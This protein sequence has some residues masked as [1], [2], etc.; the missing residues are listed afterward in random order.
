MLYGKL[1]L[2]ECF[3]CY[4]KKSKKFIIINNILNVIVFLVTLVPSIAIAVYIILTHDQ[5]NKYKVYTI[6]HLIITSLLSLLI[7]CDMGNKNERYFE[8]IL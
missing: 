5:I 4:F 2:K 1:F 6:D 7:F 3:C 8:N